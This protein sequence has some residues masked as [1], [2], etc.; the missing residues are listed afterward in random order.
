MSP[1]YKKIAHTH[2]ICTVYS[3]LNGLAETIRNTIRC[4]GNS[5]FKQSNVPY[6]QIIGGY[7]L[8]TTKYFG[9]YLA[10]WSVWDSN[11]L[12]HMGKWQPT[13]IKVNG[14]VCGF[15]VQTTNKHS[16]LSFYGVQTITAGRKKETKNPS[17]N[18]TNTTRTLWRSLTAF[19]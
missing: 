14:R 8:T 3:Y 19:R 15:P 11:P 18:F 16:S 10:D 7:P 6:N 5:N 12:P 9:S 17:L 13:G 2:C 1:T 4:K